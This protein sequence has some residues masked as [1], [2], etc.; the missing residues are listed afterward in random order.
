MATQLI[1]EE[2]PEA[3][4]ETQPLTIDDLI[5]AD[6]V[7]DLLPDNEVLRIGTHCLMEFENDLASRKG[8]EGQGW[9]DR[10]KR[11]LDIAMQ[12]RKAK[13]NPWPNASN[14]KFP[15]LTAAA[16]QFQARAY[17]AIV[18]GSNLVKGR[19]LGNDNGVPKRGPDGQIIMKVTGQPGMSG[20]P[21]I[22]DNGGPPLEPEWEVPP[23]A[24]RDRAERI[25]D[26]MTWQLLYD[27][28]G[29]EEDTDRL[30]LMLPIV[31][32]V[33][34]KTYYDPIQ[35]KNVSRMVTGLDFVINYWASSIADAP[36]FTQILRFYPHEVEERFRTGIWRTVPLPVTQSEKDQSDTAP[37]TFLEQHCRL[38]LDEDG[39]PEPYV[40]TMVRES[41]AVVRIVPCFDEDGVT[42]NMRDQTVVRIERKMYFVKYGFIP[43]PDGSF[44]DIGFGHLLDDITAA[45]DTTI[46]Q[47][48]DAGALQNAQGGFVGSGVNMKSGDIR[49]R[50]G[51]WKRM[52]VT[53]G[54]LR[55]NIVPLNLPGPSAVLMSLLELL[56]GA[57]KEITS[58]QDILTGAGQGVNTPATT[59]LAQIEQATKVMTGIFKRI[60][61]SF[62]QELRILFG[63]NRDFLDEEAY[64]A[65]TD[66]PGQIGRADYQEKD[67]D[68][69]PVSDPTMV[70]D[71]QRAMKAQA[72]LQ[73]NG[74]PLVNQVEIRRRYM[75]GTGQT[76][77]D[78]LMKVPPPQPDPAVVTE[79]AKLANER[80]KTKSTIRKDNAAAAA[81]L[82]SAAASAFTMNMI[83][84]TAS[85]AGASARLGTDAADMEDDGE[86]VD[87]PGGDGGMGIPSGDAGLP[88]VSDG[89]PGEAGGGMGGGQPDVTA[90]AGAGG[91]DGADRGIG[92]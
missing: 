90:A 87:R 23:G 44:Y 79:A 22:G 62:G 1:E 27:M 34:R 92:L 19:V 33:F 32:C 5:A 45:I 91:P 64:Y 85:L 63:L 75:E 60:H 51:E 81:S 55:E 4:D 24:K 42:M 25:G 35:R 40:V 69:V 77:I 50:L 57:A 16:I 38:D 46:N 13:S 18:D 58:V 78:E 3:V 14:V 10:Y 89:L 43:S 66:T 70:N 72:L 61:R 15:L 48:L 59:V 84:T 9:E 73:F 26:H 30:L 17:P 52:D 8:E 20:M 76:N 6:N 54:T 88:P 41:G 68:V 36:R 65:L 2:P 53:G 31:G 67:V 82:M 80:D 86:P 71:A 28:P 21:G 39:Y 7:A 49:F 56:I 29:W 47:L 74:D 12:V 83:E 37:I 11:Y